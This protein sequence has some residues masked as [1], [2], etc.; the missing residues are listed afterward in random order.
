MAQFLS[1]QLSI[2]ALWSR[3]QGHDL[4]VMGSS[5]RMG[6]ELSSPSPSTPPSTNAHVHTCSLS[7]SQIHTQILKKKKRRKSHIDTERYVLEKMQSSKSII[8]PF[9]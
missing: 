9:T 5:P 4:R 3:S 8:I 6:S 2:L 7:L 1:F